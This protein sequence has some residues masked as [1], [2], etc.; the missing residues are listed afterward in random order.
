[1]LIINKT[2]PF[3]IDEKNKVIRMGNFKDTGKEIEYEEDNI[4]CIFNH[5]T[6]PIEKEELANIV[7]KET[8]LDKIEVSNAIEYLIKENFIINDSNYNKLLVDNQYNRQDLFFSMFNETYL[9]VINKIQNKNI[10][11]LGLGGIGSNVALMLSRTGFDT[12]TL[13]D[14]DRVERSNLIRQY[15]YNEK[16]IGKL[17]TTALESKLNKNSSINKKNIQILRKED[18]KET[19]KKADIVVCTLDKPFRIIRRLINDICMEFN[20]PVIFSGFA[21]HVGIIGPFVVPNQT[22]CLL[23]IEKELSEKPLN[24]VK[25]VPSY[26]PLCNIISS[27]VT[28]EI[29]N[30]FVNYNK[31]NLIGKSLMFN[32]ATYETEI[33]NWEKNKKCK[34]CGENA[35]K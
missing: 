21:E 8:G 16:D 2:K 19:I 17:K 20:K 30:Y 11:I 4:L 25:V 22:A 18:I 28:N 15:P 12:F 24:N 6:S 23:C 7:S 32:M 1:M 35:S 13:V 10:V 9:P 34:V 14:F 5:L 31:N 26:G 33:M 29:I 27:V 3:Y